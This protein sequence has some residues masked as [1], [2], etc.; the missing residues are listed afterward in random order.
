MTTAKDFI[1]TFMIAISNCSL[2]SKEHEAFDDLAKKTLS[3]L[4]VLIKE[5]LEIMMLDSEL[6]VNSV[7]LRDT[8]LHKVNI[9]QRFKRKGISRVD[10]LNGISL[11]EIKQFI[12]DM[13]A[14]G[15]EITSYPHI[16]CGTVDIDAATSEAGLGEYAASN[17]IDK[18]RDVFHSAS[19]F[20]KLNISGLDEVVIHFIAAFKR[21]SS[22]LKYL[23]PVKSFSEY[24]YTHAT[25][26]AVLSLF[27]AETLGID[28]D[29]LHDIGIA[30]LLHDAGKLFISNDIL[31]KNGRLDKREFDEIKK[32]PSYGAGYLSKMDDISRLPRS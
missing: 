2:Y 5:S 10:F 30:A 14:P 19:P 24:T 13:A 8:G 31:E 22:I 28:S 11:S 26:V 20:K 16:K 3:S 12:V 25:N 18:V 1:S 6:V 29:M 15:K 17:V 7:P 23:S 27:Q 4:T 21:E 9:M 32:H